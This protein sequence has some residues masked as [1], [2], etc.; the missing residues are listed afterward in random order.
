VTLYK[1]QHPNL[2]SVVVT[3]IETE[4]FY[5]AWERARNSSAACSDRKWFTPTIAPL[6][7]QRCAIAL[8]MPREA[9]VTIIDLPERAFNGIE[10]KD[11]RCSQHSPIDVNS[12]CLNRPIFQLTC[13]ASCH[14]V[15]YISAGPIV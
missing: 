15:F 3:N 5:V 6:S 10:A 13:E 7:A 4:Q 1:V 9:P 14:V 2:G 12:P 8:P 11:N